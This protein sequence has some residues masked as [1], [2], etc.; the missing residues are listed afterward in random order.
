MNHEHETGAA[1]TPPPASNGNGEPAWARLQRVALVAGGVGIAV[2]AALGLMQIGQ[3]GGERQFF[4]SYLTGWVFW[5]SLPVGC[6]GWIGITYVTGAS[7][8]VLLLR[9]FEAASRTLPL[10]AVLFIPIGVSV[11]ME[12]ASPYPWTK[13]AEAYTD[14][15][16]DR[17]EL[18]AKFDEW[19]NPTGFVVRTVIYFAVWGL[20]V[21]LMNK[22]GRRV[23]ETGD[24]KARRS[25][26]NLAGPVIVV[27]ALGN[28]FVC[29]DYVMSIELRWASTMF[30]V[31]YSVNQLLT[32]LVFCVAIFLTLA[33]EPP[34]RNVLRPKFQIDMGSM[35]L[36]LT[37]VW[38]YAN[39]AQYMLIWI[40]NMPEEIHYY[41]LRTR[42]G[43]EWAARALALL[44]FAVPFLLLLFRD[45]KLHPKRL[46]AMGI[47]IM[48]LCALDVLWWL[49][50]AYA[51]E[52]GPLFLLMD[53]AAIIGIG[54]VWGWL[55][56]GQLKKAPLVSSAY[57][58]D[59]PKGHDHDH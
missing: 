51:H 52:N 57:V 21:F 23:E 47:L 36:A 27:F 35:M 2:Y 54:G 58:A 12:K 55:F 14:V 44:H 38:S 22:W 49:E 43:W 6:L 7:W 34:L 42:G 53:V 50:P 40:A 16:A 48:T 19:S 59:L 41:A 20:L 5:L 15:E 10:M 24:P 1:A 32:C 33:P 56:L 46:R 28:M 45:V 29:T 25:M 37:M 3:P 18:Q 11:F 4:L 17:A 30:P 13:K 8:G 31:I 39:F 9:L 26:E